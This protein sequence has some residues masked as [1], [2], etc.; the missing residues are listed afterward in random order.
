MKFLLSQ[1]ETVYK[2]LVSTLHCTHLIENYKQNMQLLGSNLL[3]GFH[4]Y[5]A[6]QFSNEMS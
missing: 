1:A 5:H 4:L 3:P 2:L 6:Y